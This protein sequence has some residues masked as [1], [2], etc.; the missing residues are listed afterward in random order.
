[1]AQRVTVRERIDPGDHGIP[2]CQL[3]LVRRCCHGSWSTIGQSTRASRVASS[4]SFS[5]S[6]PLR[7]YLSSRLEVGKGWG[8]PSSSA[9]TCAGEASPK[10]GSG[11]PAPGQYG[12]GRQEPRLDILE[13]SFTV[14]ANGRPGDGSAWRF[15]DP[16]YRDRSKLKTYE[17]KTVTK[18]VPAD[19]GY[20]RIRIDGLDKR[21]DPRRLGARLGDTYRPLILRAELKMSVNGARVESPSV[22]FQEEHRFAVHAAGTTLKGLVWHSGARRP[23]RRLHSRAALLQAWPPHHRWRVLRPSKRS[24]SLWHGSPRR[25]DRAG[26]PVPLTMNKSD[27]A[28]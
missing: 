18:R 3:S 11:K 24:S 9:T 2:V 7:I 20:V 26:T 28:Q 13:T 15:A 25:R 4:R 21:L 22:N 17:L 10:R 16:D 1:M 8:R 27:F 14:E 6:S 19:Q 5:A 12:Q 23:G